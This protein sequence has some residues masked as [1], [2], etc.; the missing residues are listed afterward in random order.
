MSE[1]LGPAEYGPDAEPGAAVTT[2]R[3]YRVVHVTR[4]TYSDDVSTSYGRAHLLPRSTEGQAVLDSNVVLTPPAD[5]FRSHVDYFGNTSSYY[6]V[7]TSHIELEVSAVSNVRI[8]REPASLAALNAMTWEVARDQIADDVTMHAYTLP[9]PLVPSLDELIAY[10]TP[11]FAPGRPLGD[12]LMELVHRI[13][14]DFAYVSGSTTVKTPLTDVFAQ[15]RGVCQDFAHVAI[16]CLRSVGLPT[17]YV[18]GYLETTPPPGMPKLQGADQ[19]H[20]WAAVRIPGLEWVDIDPTNDQFVDNRY[21]TTAW[22]RDY[23]DV[24]PLKGVILTDAK[25]STLEVSVDVF[26]VN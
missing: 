22:G 6:T 11:S 21:I 1:L 14:T 18:S 3:D 7:R 5:E 23:S 10:A 15:R 16:A 19:S 26:R 12:A 8:W 17:R 9:S 2:A 13:Y 20:A 25:D 24:P 4:Y